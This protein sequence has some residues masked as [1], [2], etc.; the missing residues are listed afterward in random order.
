MN[1]LVSSNNFETISLFAKN[2]AIAAFGLLLISVLPIIAIAQDLQ[3]F[4]EGRQVLILRHADTPGNGDPAN[5]QIDDCSTQ[6]NL[7]EEG[8][9]QA[10][11]LG[12]YLRAQGIENARVFTSQLCRSLDTAEELDVGDIEDVTGLNSF[13]T[14]SEYNDEWLTELRTLLLQFGRRTDEP[15]VMVTHAVTIQAIAGVSAG[16]GEAVLLDR[17]AIGPPTFAEQLIVHYTRSR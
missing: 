6:R 12:G 16:S 11:R 4:A 10:P 17:H 15:V 13:Y 7:S 8:R 14:Y 1:I 2:I 3:K 5:F 9:Q